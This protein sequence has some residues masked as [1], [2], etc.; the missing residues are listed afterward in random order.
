MIIFELTPV[1]RLYVNHM[2]S[3]ERTNLNSHVFHSIFGLSDQSHGALTNKSK[4]CPVGIEW[5]STTIIRCLVIDNWSPYRRHFEKWSTA[6]CTTTSKLIF[7]FIN[8]LNT[9][10][11]LRCYSW[12]IHR[13]NTPKK[14][15]FYP[16]KILVRIWG[17]CGHPQ[18]CSSLIFTSGGAGP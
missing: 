13:A 4:D 5:S 7:V 14:S 6:E 3:N 10:E 9:A 17:C 11:S 15:M 16:K 18:A 8:T 12:Y 1:W 2:T